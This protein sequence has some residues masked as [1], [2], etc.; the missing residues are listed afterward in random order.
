MGSQM[1]SVV[2]REG[3]AL[4]VVVL[5]LLVLA[6]IASAAVA[7]AVGQV[8]SAVAAGQLLAA[9][10]SA[11]AELEA[12]FA[13]TTGATAAVAGGAAVELA[14]GTS[15]DGGTW[16]VL[17][18]RITAEHHLL[19]GEATTGR[20]VSFRELRPAWWIDPETRV[21]DH[22]AVVEGAETEVAAGA[23]ARTDRLLAARPGVE[24]CGGR[25]ALAD[26]F[27]ARVVPPT[28]PLPAAG[29]RTDRA[30]TPA[31][32]VDGGG[33]EVAIG[34]LRGA[35]LRRSAD[36]RLPLGNDCSEC[37]KGLVT[38]V[39]DA[40]LT[41]S[42]RGVLAVRGDVAFAP[43]SSWTGLVVASGN[44]QVQRSATVTGL[45]RAGGRVALADGAVVDGSAC[46][47]LRALESAGSVARPFPVSGS[48]W[49]A[50]FA[51]SGP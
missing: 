18:L 29:E 33:R 31:D 28:G 26:A 6:G 44:V 45:V 23:R 9:R 19:V 51:P 25:K 14:S 13:R 22:R 39:G 34:L 41:G 49:G 17:D 40:V 48:S 7:A 42:G 8:R 32:S 2:G 43:G 16:R 37:W 10:A 50:A 47:A 11:R 24:A 27:G 46:A 20:G 4:A 5:A 3:F 35:T 36:S 38:G 15:G 21:A 30:G 12:V 1:R